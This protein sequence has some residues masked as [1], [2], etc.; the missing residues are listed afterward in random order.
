MTMWRMLIACWI[1][2]ATNILSEY[3]MLINFPLQQCLHEHASMLRYTYVDCVVL[4]KI[5]SF[6]LRFSV[7]VTSTC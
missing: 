4:D 5:I 2:K 1:P 6:A 3:V 7:F